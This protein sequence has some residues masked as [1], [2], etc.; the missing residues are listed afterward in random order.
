MTALSDSEV[1]LLLKD[2]PDW[3][4]RDDLSISRTYDFDTYLKGLR[5]FNTIAAFAEE[6]NHHP[7]LTLDY[8]K[9]TV[10]WT[11]H[12][13]GGLHHQDFSCAQ[14]CDA[15]FEVQLKESTS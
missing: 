6:L 1:K 8:K 12:D 10:C 5:F 3:Q 13:I 11:T 15:H 4:L 7:A 9:L 2:L 14:R